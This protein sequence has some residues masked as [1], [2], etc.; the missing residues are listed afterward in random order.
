MFSYLASKEVKPKEQRTDNRAFEP[1]AGVLTELNLKSRFAMPQ[2]R[3][4]LNDSNS[5]I[6][7]E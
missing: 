7:Q 6:L 4:S 1:A 3:D 2:Y 5:Y